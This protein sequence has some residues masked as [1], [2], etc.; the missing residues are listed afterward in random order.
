MF[1]ANFWWGGNALLG[2]VEVFAECHVRIGV[3]DRGFLMFRW[4]CKDGIGEIPEVV[5]FPHIDA[6]DFVVVVCEKLNV[7]F[8]GVSAFLSPL[9]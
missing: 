4:W 1:S 3:V 8:A 2:Q 9:V 7:A 6:M 5:T